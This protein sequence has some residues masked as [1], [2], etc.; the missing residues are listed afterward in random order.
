MSSG[1]GKHRAQLLPD[2][3]ARRALIGFIRT[4]IAARSVVFLIMSGRMPNLYLP[5]GDYA[6]PSLELRHI[7][8][9]DG[10]QLSP[11]PALPP[12]RNSSIVAVVYGIAM[13]LTF[14]NEFGMW[15]HFGGSYWRTGQCGDA[16]V[17]VAALLALVACAK[18][19]RICESRHPCW[20]LRL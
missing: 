17:V 3:L 6:C 5:L 18:S 7:P 2:Q 16:I 20:G 14:D 12:L 15:L 10:Q 8:A 11:V 9:R 19:I 13:A 1:D 4:F